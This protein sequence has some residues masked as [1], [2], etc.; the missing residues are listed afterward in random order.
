MPAY[1]IEGPLHRVYRADEHLINLKTRLDRMIVDQQHALG[2][3]FD[4]NPPHDLRALPTP[5][6]DAPM[7]IPILIGEICYNLRSAMDN[8]IFELSRHDCRI[9]HK[10]T[11]FPIEDCAKVFQGRGNSYLQGINPAHV[12]A[13]ERLQPYQGCTWSKALR[14]MSNKDKHREFVSLRGDFLITGYSEVTDADYASLRYPIHRTKHPIH[15]EM[16]VKLRIV[17]KITL[18][19]WTP[20]VQTL[21]EIKTGVTQ[22][23]A[24]FKPE[25]K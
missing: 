16:D 11:Q 19:D 15:G 7:S 5:I 22:A 13:I 18:D 21:E 25:F 23:L 10:R 8:L 12:A 17:A 9:E 24:D 14:T 6:I 20:I 2:I 4:P 3:H 1:P